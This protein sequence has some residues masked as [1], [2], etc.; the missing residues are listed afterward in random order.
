VS[1]TLGWRP[2]G[3][4]EQRLHDAIDECEQLWGN[5]SAYKDILFNLDKVEQELDH[6]SSSPGHRAALRA[7]KPN[8]GGQDPD[9]GR[10]RPSEAEKG[11]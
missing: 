5:D 7:G 9:S 4:P 10:E 3:D 6:V 1:P 2:V 11:Y 8:I